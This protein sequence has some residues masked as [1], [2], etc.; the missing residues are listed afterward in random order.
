MAPKIAIIGDGSAYA[1]GL[2]HAFIQQA[3]TFDSG[4]GA[5]W[6]WPPTTWRGCAV[7]A[8]DESAGGRRTHIEIS[9]HHP[10]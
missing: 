5:Q 9:R 6:M 7:G 1:P 8:Q 10:A 2:I 3:D 4:T